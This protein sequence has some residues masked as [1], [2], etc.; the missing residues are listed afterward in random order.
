MKKI[1]VL[2]TNILLH[3]ARALLGFGENDVCIPIYVFEE[4]DNFKKDLSELGRNAREVSRMIDGYRKLGNLSDG[5][6]LETGGMLSVRFAKDGL[7]PEM[8]VG[9]QMD[10]RIMAV[11]LDLQRQNEEKPVVF[12]TKDTNLRIRADAIGLAAV[13]YDKGDFQVNQLYPDTTE[14]TVDTQ[15]IDIVYSGDS[16]QLSEVN[17]HDVEEPIFPNQYILLRDANR[18][19]RTVLG[20]ITA[21][22]ESIE[23]IRSFKESFWGIRPRNMEQHFALDALLRPDIQLVTLM[24]KAGTGKTLLALAA[25]LHQTMDEDRYRKLLV[26]RPIFPLGRDLGYLPGDLEE[27]LSPWMQPIHDNVEFLA[28]LASRG[29][30]NQETYKQLLESGSIEIEALTYIRGRSIPKQFLIVDEAQNLT[31][32][33][34]KTVLTRAGEGTKLVFT[35]DP[36]QIDH[37]YVDAVN[38]G[39]TYIAE[40][41]KSEGIAAHVVLSKGERS[42]L[43]EIAANL[44]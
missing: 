13:D 44:L 27:K 28:T 18:P 38:N 11:A 34:V 43:A 15:A 30:K 10:N 32:H 29:R 9:H 33:E 35:G 8:S 37:P 7:P 24:G 41:F 2:D 21:D 42:P 20:R 23:K 19:A 5:V 17:F 3:D 25:G 14:F 22:G 1:F 4:I 39:L 6:Q 16:V 36:H 40:R 31:P 12:V 26:S